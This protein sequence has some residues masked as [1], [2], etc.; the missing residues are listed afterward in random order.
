MKEERE[1]AIP[2]SLSLSFF[3]LESSCL[4]CVPLPRNLTPA[5]SNMCVYAYYTHEPGKKKK[6]HKRGVR[7]LSLT[8]HSRNEGRTGK[9]TREK[10][11][12][13]NENFP[14]TQ[15][16]THEFPSL[17]LRFKR[18]PVGG[19]HFRRLVV[20]R[21]LLLMYLYRKTGVGSRFDRAAN[22]S[23]PCFLFFQS[24]TSRPRQP[25]FFFLLHF[26]TRHHPPP[27]EIGIPKQKRKR[28]TKFMDFCY[29]SGVRS[30]GNI[31]V[32]NAYR[33]TFDSLFLSGSALLS[34]GEI[35]S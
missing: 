25:L 12:R 9:K 14:H 24:Q 17:L 4:C 1:T 6:T 35:E 5:G 20:G 23:G 11:P 22:Y 3:L 29:T 27:T 33:V 32:V 34:S 19:V 30:R 2:L 18:G 7:V 10:S 28:S 13:E 21:F 8:L 16:R 26:D 15:G 31:G